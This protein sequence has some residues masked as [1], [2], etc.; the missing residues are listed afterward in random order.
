MI[1]NKDI[2]KKGL[3]LGFQLLTAICI[4]SLASCAGNDSEN[5][6]INNILWYKEPAEKW[7]E[8]LPVGNG[9]IGAVVF[10]GIRN[11]KLGLNISTLWSGEPSNKNEKPTGIENL[12]KIRTLLFNNE[13]AEAEKLCSE[14]LIGNKENY[15]THLPMGNL[16]FNFNFESDKIS[17]YTR[18]LDI[19][20]A[21]S[22]VEFENAG[23]TCIREV[24]VSHPDDLLLVKFTSGKKKVLTTSIRFD[25]Q[26]LP[27][28]TSKI[29]DQILGIEGDAFEKVH[30]NGKVG[31]HFFSAIQVSDCDGIVETTKDGIE[32]S[33]A[34]YIEL[35][36]SA[37]TNYKSTSPKEKC[38][39]QLNAVEDKTYNEIKKHHVADY[40]KLF[41]RANLFLG[42]SSNANIPTNERIQSLKNPGDDPQ[43]YA[44]F[45]NFARYLLIAS[46]REDSQLPGNL[47]GI[48]NDN[49]AC[50]MPWTCDF[51]LDINMQQNY[52]IAES[53]NLSECHEPL[54]KL[55]DGLVEPGRQTAQNL[56]NQDGWVA[57]V[58]TNAWGYTAP[59]WGLGWGLNVTGGA[60]IASHLWNRYEYTLD[61]EF[62][63]N[64]AYPVLKDA[65][66]FFNGYLT[67][68]P[69]NGLLVSGPSVSPENKY[70]DKNGNI[71]S[72]T[73]GATCDAVLIRDLFKSCIQA[74]TILNVDEEFR[75]E[76]IASRNKLQPLTIGKHGQLQ[77][78]LEDYEDAV[79]NHRH[80]SHL[81]A[82]YPG[83]Q[84]TPNETQE[85]AQAAKVTIEK[86][87]SQPNWED[88]EWS[89]GNFINFYARL[90]DANEA[91]KHLHG[92]IRENAGISMLTYS[93][94]GIA[95]AQQDIFVIDGNFAGASGISEMLVQSYNNK[96]YILPA[97]PSSWSDGNFRGVCTRNGFE[98]NLE[99]KQGQLE[100]L[101]VLSK[102]GKTC[103][104]SYKG[105]TASFETN[106]GQLYLLGENLN[107][108]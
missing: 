39:A 15:G 30:S 55:I 87:L 59:G 85:L 31:V 50:K 10:G 22:K 28:R 108:M 14:H 56:Y 72:E 98:L 67:E 63:K 7:I 61:Q 94:G 93:R 4:I 86:R 64:R 75:Q 24:F 62:L 89:R 51:H 26:G 11:E 52:W 33:E 43:L 1:N 37:N 53:G 54:F 105:K 12:E 27:V 2:Q 92:L 3:K 60:W 65:A 18:E 107:S 40:Q 44:L 103:N 23:L 34:S 91:L 19:Q 90:L 29:S 106:E 99:W 88:V 95:G 35:R 41:S 84:I 45:Y 25:S 6:D 16:L 38:M 17:G 49:F 68:H 9:K 97:L 77:E 101:E 71:C 79:P 80:T 70:L 46:S 82:L 21:I 5:S 20:K 47:Q 66:V 73:M 48:W 69:E 104:I 36:I 13:F 32:V 81:I 83:S 76:L 58:F 8:T 102:K 78:W 100:R 74:S 57:H 96:I 42:N